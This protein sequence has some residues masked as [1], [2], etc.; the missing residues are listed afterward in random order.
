[1]PFR[2]RRSIK[3]APGIRLNVGKSGISSTTIGHTNLRRGY[4][5]RTTI[6]L[7][8]GLSWFFGGKKKGP[9]R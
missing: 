9:R 7:F 6:R 4:T 1:M 5:P 3:V 8:P 2:F